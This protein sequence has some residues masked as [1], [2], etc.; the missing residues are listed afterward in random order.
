MYEYNLTPEGTKVKAKLKRQNSV[1]SLK[2]STIKDPLPLTGYPQPSSPRAE[3]TLMREYQGS[4]PVPMV[5]QPQINQTPVHYEHQSQYQ[6]TP[7]YQQSPQQQHYLTSVHQDSTPSQNNEQYYVN[8]NHYDERY[9]TPVKGNSYE[10]EMPSTAAK[11]TDYKYNVE[12]NPEQEGGFCSM[13][14]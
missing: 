1:S 10:K 2:G 8:N 11:D 14:G 13:F 3:H 12:N 5:Q 7:Q 4:V 6:Q 9:M